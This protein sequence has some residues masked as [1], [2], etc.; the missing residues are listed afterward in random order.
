[1]FE[2]HSPKRFSDIVTGD[3]TWLHF[4]ITPPKRLNRMWVDGQ[5]D[6]PA[7]LRP[8]FQSRKRMF[9]VFFNFRGSLAVDILPQDTSM[10]LT[11]YVQD[12]LSHVKSA[13]NEQRSKVSTSKTLFLHDNAGPHKAKATTQSLHELGIQVLPHPAYSPDFAPFSSKTVKTGTKTTVIINKPNEQ[14]QQQQQQSLARE[15]NMIGQKVREQ[16]KTQIFGLE[17]APRIRWVRKDGA[18]AK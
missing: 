3:K 1:M 18:A 4:F 12:V 17:A 2:R 14:Q 16:D 6:R 5:V 7:M 8:G 9:T 11:Y 15:E 10:T 13:I